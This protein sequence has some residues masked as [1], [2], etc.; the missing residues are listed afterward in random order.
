M[1][2]P[3]AN[4]H[5]QASQPIESAETVQQL[6]G[7]AL[8]PAG[9]PQCRQAFL[10]QASRIGQ[11]CSHCGRGKLEIQPALVR[12]EPP[13]LMIGFQKG[14]SDLSPI[15]KDFVDGVWLHN[16]DFNPQ[17]LARRAMPVF[18]PMWLVDSDLSGD[19]LAEI[20]FDYQVKS[21]QESFRNS[22]W[23]SHEIIENRVRWDLRTGQL[24]R[25]YDNVAVPA[26]SRHQELLGCVQNYHTSTTIPY[27]T[28]LL[29]QADLW[30]PD[31]HPENAWPLAQS[32]F[33]QKASE[34]C[35][36]AAVGQHIRSFTL[37][38]SYDK[39]N[40]TQLLLPMYVTFY[41]DDTGQAHLVYINGEN[42]AIGGVRL[43][44]QRK[45]WQLAGRLAAIA[46]LLLVLGVLGLLATALLP[47]A[48]ALGL[49]FIFLAFVLGI[50]AIIPAAWP[51][52]WNRSQQEH[53]V[54]SR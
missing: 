16:D 10:V 8:Q 51:W 26:F 7:V 37:H 15:F 38:A 28:D 20:G 17:D 46:A 4:L 34:D 45:G 19:W 14:K 12:K 31:I 50:G 43:A 11:V 41:T 24:S 22:S 49:L 6:W 30:T 36:K 13:E 42:G 32:A 23:Q 52:Q 2:T 53:K 44:S 3:N 29:G 5:P 40:W 27:R 48:G 47:P 9:C 39:T 21:S 35:Q 54:T 18:W 25:H 1:E 33:N